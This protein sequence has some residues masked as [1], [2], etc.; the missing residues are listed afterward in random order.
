[1]PSNST[2]PYPTI[3]EKRS[4]EPP[5]QFIKPDNSGSPSFFCWAIAVSRTTAPMKHRTNP[6]QILIWWRL[7][8]YATIDFPRTL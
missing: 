5:A 2:L 3:Q 6:F 8:K 1:M 7:R 4:K